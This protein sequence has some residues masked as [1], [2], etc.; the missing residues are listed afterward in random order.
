MRLSRSQPG[1]KKPHRYRHKGQD[2][3]R[4]V[5][6]PCLS[7]H[8]RRKLHR[9]PNRRARKFKL[10][11]PCILSVTF[12][13]W[14]LAIG[15]G[16][17]RWDFAG[18]DFLKVRNMKLNSNELILILNFCARP[19]GDRWRSQTRRRRR[20]IRRSTTDGAE[21]QKIVFF[22][23][24]YRSYGGSLVARV[25]SLFPSLYQWLLLKHWRSACMLN[26]VGVSMRES[27]C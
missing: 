4:P 13:P 10:E 23:W 22:R 14:N 12:R 2:G 15:A 8:R 25:S 11:V 18:P 26:S 17:Y 16:I 1:T 9:C 24:F 20:R 3:L 5:R 21:Y 19:F 7:H 27:L 6:P